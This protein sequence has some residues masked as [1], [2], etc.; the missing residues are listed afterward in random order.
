MK[1]CSEIQYY[2]QDGQGIHS[3]VCFDCGGDDS[4]ELDEDHRQLLHDC[5]DEWLNKSNGTGF[6]FVA[7][8]DAL[9]SEFRGEL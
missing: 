2:K 7:D 6:F 3:D 1:F 9:I 5:L 4:K 8:R